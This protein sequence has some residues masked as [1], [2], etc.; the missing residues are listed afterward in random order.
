MKK[1]LITGGCGFIGSNASIFFKKKGL[2]VHCLDNL[3]R[4][5]SDINKKIILKNKIK[6]FKID[7]RNNLKIKN[8]I[9]NNNYDY[10]LHLAGQVAVTTSVINPL[11]DYMINLE[12]TFNLLEAIRLHSPKTHLLYASTNKVYGK[13]NDSHL[14]EG[15]NRYKITKFD[16]TDER[17]SLNFLS[18]YGCSKG[19]ADQYVIDYA[20]IYNLNT[21]SFRQSCIY[22]P[23]QLGV[24]DQGWVAWFTIA[25]ALNKKIFVYGNGKQIRDVLH[26][27]DLLNA[28]FLCFKNKKKSKGN[29]YN[30]GGGYKNTL[31]LLELI[32]MLNKEFKIE[33][34]IQK[35]G[36]RPG[37]QKVFISNNEKFISHTGW[38]IKNNSSL[39]ILN[40]I[41]WVKSKDK[42]LKKL[43]K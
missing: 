6:F 18:P 17:Q 19:A 41:K 27:D 14:T 32:R 40:L 3:S 24:E 23:N 5:G 29:A 33:K 4:K 1:I 28:Y 36:W 10:I 21:T 39:G 20:N 11:D 42:M 12:A 26:V 43:F 9:K 13:I 15:L 35:K 16:A 2:E 22:G 8:I 38:E 34:N 37:D 25:Y 30:I 7:I 31:S